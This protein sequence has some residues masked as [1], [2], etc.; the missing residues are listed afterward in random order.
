MI[1]QDYD[2]SRYEIVLILDSCADRSEELSMRLLSKCD[3]KS[4][5]ILADVRNAGTARNIGLK[6]ARG[7]YIY[8]ADGDDYLTDSHALEKLMNGINANNANAVYMTAFESEDGEVE[9]ADA[10]WRFFYKRE[11]IGN[12]EFMPLDINEDWEF[13]RAIR[14]KCDYTENRIND[15]LYHYTHPREGS[16]T[17]QYRLKL[18]AKRVS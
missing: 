18:L 13:A 1:D 4:R 12:T 10:I 15:V 11:I 5:V 8:F 3:V 16:I 6:M 9:E 7:K 14:R 2:K 17:E